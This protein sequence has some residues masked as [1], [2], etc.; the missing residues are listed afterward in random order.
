[1]TFRVLLAL[2]LG[3]LAM[4]FSASAQPSRLDE[5]LAKLRDVQAFSAHFR[6]EKRIALLAA[7]LVSEGDVYYTR[8]ARLIRR[9]RKPEASLLVMDART[10]RFRDSAGSHAMS[11][12]ENPSVSALTSTLLHV[13]SGDRRA[14]EEGAKVEEE[15]LASG[16]FRLRVVPK[17]Q[18]VQKLVRAMTFEGV[19]V[20]LSRMTMTDGNGDEA[21]TEF[22]ALR[23]R[24]PFSDAEWT[25][26][27]KLGE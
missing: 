11:L 20:T 24:K 22:S 25:K 8:P 1:M 15:A 23:I 3:L 16:G 26:L 17:T 27:E 19:G 7:P 5:I 12:N 6:E 14:L 18:A 13:L 9:T 21:V 10:L 2:A 4:T